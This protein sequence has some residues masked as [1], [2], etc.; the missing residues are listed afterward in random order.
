MRILITGADGFAG[1][2]LVNELISTTQGL[3]IH[4]TS[5]LPLPSPLPHVTTHTLDLRDEQAVASLI[6]EIAPERIYHLAATA[7]VGQSYSAVWSTLENNIRA[8]VNLILACL[9]HHLKPR[10]LVISSGDIYGDQLA[11]RPATENM[12]LRPGNPYSVSKVTQDMLALQYHLSNGL[13]IMR[14]RPFNHLGPGQNRGFVAPDFADQIA[15][16]EAGQQEAVI[17]VGNLLAERDFTDVRDVMR[18]YRLIMEMGTPGD[19]YNVSSGKTCTIGALLNLLLSYSS[20]HIEVRVDS[21][22]LRPGS[23]SKV[24]GD[25][26]HLRALTGWQPTIP[27]SQTLL[28]V[29]EDYRQRVRALSE[30]SKSE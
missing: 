1:R 25:S 30:K 7:N 29:L 16:I 8:Q 11:D 18:A 3:E 26:S 6:A 27:L 13:P 2:H 4:G 24:W 15:R 22:R 21:T 17:H 20:A 12:P 19:V 5:F 28:D 14:A 10:M 9:D 23:F